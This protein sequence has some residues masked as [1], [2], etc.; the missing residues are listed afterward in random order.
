MSVGALDPHGELAAYSNS[1]DW[2]LLL[3][4]GTGLISTV[5]RVSGVAGSLPPVDERGCPYPNPNHQARGF[6]RWGGTSFAAAWVSARIAAHLL[7]DPHGAHL[8]DLALKT[9]MA[10]AATALASTQEDIDVW[11]RQSSAA[12]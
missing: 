8:G 10:R 4:P 11:K 1:G 7:D 3:A 5:P 6:A 12:E 9:T 2:V